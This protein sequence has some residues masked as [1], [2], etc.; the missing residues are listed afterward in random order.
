MKIIIDGIHGFDGT[1]EM[2]DDIGWTNRELHIIKRISG[3]RAGEIVE[4]LQAGDN[5][6]IVAIAVIAVRQSG[7]DWQAFETVVW[8]SESGSII[9][10]D[11]EDDDAVPSIPSP[12]PADSGGSEAKPESSGLGSSGDGDDLPETNLRAIGS[13]G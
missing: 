3:V 7:K 4:A 13:Q 11:K 8:E 9:V 5:D 10:P 6:V 1:Y 12:P 2:S